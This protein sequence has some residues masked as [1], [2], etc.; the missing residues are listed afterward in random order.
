M[1]QLQDY[2]ITHS[3]V[4]NMDPIVLKYLAAR[5]INKIL[6]NRTT[7]LQSNVRSRASLTPVGSRVQPFYMQYRTL[8]IGTGPEVHL[9]LRDFGH[10]NNLSARH[11]N[12]FYD[13][14]SG[15]YE[16]INYSHF[17]TKVDE[18]MYS[19][20]TAVVMSR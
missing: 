16:L 5:Q 20:D 12:L 7:L 14:L 1:E 2:L 6:P 9:N 11:A 15:Q 8:D 10:C 13:E 18:C 17:G 19:L 4:D 3:E